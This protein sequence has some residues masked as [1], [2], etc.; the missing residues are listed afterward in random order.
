MPKPQYKYERTVAE[1]FRNFNY[2]VFLND[3]A[4]YNCRKA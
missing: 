4:P 3:I 2:L 1:S